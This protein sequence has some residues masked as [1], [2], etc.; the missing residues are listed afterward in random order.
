MGCGLISALMGLPRI[1]FIAVWLL[2]PG[3]IARGLDGNT[4]FALLGFLF[5]PLTT[6]GFA[7]GINSLGTA[8]EMSSLGW[9]ITAV[10]FAVDIGLVSRTPRRKRS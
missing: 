1:G 3:Y 2:Q 9:G 8:G 5:L 10:G 4:L 6:M 7:Y